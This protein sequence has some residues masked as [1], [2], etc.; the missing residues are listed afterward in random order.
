MPEGKSSPNIIYGPG[1]DEHEHSHNE[2]F[3]FDTIKSEYLGSVA[4]CSS[5]HRKISSDKLSQVHSLTHKKETMDK[6]NAT[7]KTCKDC[8]MSS[9]HSFNQQTE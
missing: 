4:F 3:G 7:N 2:A 6:S 1:W 8:H 9:G 5:Y